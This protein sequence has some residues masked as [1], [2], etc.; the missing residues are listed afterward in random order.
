MTVRFE[1]LE[2]ENLKSLVDELN[3]RSKEYWFNVVYLSET[4]AVLD[5]AVNLVTVVDENDFTEL[6][7]NSAPVNPSFA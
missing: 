3:K 1:H 2:S 7:I 4:A 6:E 5:S